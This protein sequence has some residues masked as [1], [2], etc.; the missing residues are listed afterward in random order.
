MPKY[1]C[2]YCDIYL[3]HSSPAGRRQHA[4]GRKHINQKIEYFQ[5][6]IREPDFMP[7]QQLDS[8]VVQRAVQAAG[9]GPMPMGPAGGPGFQ[10]GFGGRGGFA[11]RGGMM[12][13]GMDGG[14]GGG[15]GGFPPM[16]MSIGPGG[17]PP[18]GR[19][20]SMCGSHHPQDIRSG[21]ASGPNSNHFQRPM[22]PMGLRGPLGPGGPGPL[23]P[24]GMR[25][26][27]GPPGNHF[28]PPGDDLG[29]RR[30]MSGFDRERR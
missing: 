15:R 20:G 14:R 19:S 17:G 2:E 5:N 3:T 10:R 25:G 13:G 9:S 11:G 29:P 16:G 7:P 18:G 12:R 1:Y 30:N 27:G 4:T 21:G 24:G 28:G 8:T 26:P 23:G 6:L 22:G